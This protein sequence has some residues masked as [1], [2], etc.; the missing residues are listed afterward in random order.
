MKELKLFRIKLKLEAPLILGYTA[1]DH[2]LYKTLKF[3]PSTTLRGGLAT[4]LLY[5]DDVCVYDAFENE[6]KEKFGKCF[7]CL[8]KQSCQFYKFFFEDIFS[9]TNGL[10]LVDESDLEGKD[11]KSRK[12][13]SNP[14]IV[15]VH[16]LIKQCK[17]CGE[18]KQKYVN[19]F[20]EWLR[21]NDKNPYL[22]SNCKEPDCLCNTTMDVVK[23]K[24]YCKNCNK[25]TG[26]PKDDLTVSTGINYAKNSSLTGFLFSYS[27][28]EQGSIFEG[29]LT[30]ENNQ[31]ILKSIEK[32]TIRLGRGKSR[33]FGKIKV[34]LEPI[35][36]QDRINKNKDTLEQ[37][38]N[39]DN[40][41]MAA[42]TSIFDFDISQKDPPNLIT[43]PTINIAS[44]LKFVIS[45][46]GLEL[47][48]SDN[49]TLELVS[50]MG[51][52]E[53]FSGWSYKTDQPKPHISAATRGSL[54]KFKVNGQI[55][56]NLKEALAYMEFV[57]LNKYSRL[58]YNLI[59][60]P[61]SEEI[62][63]K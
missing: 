38:L 57:G 43:K 39:H 21:L 47:T 35:D 13:C 14:D 51:E 19:Q 48:D 58:G 3:I 10:F 30:C 22:R 25:L 23:N 36:L 26:S 2:N 62:V 60:Y 24:N 15:P 32:T 34:K 6:D 5:L 7:S 37:M 63:K 29:Y 33:G 49:N 53:T 45:H 11:E 17:R 56:E 59:Y 16:P 31:S 27:Y 61:T 4:E 46:M 28:L 52:L 41:I 8:E 18:P 44:A 55:N 20:N 42:K 54:F 40:I 9:L 1:P 50:S 12:I